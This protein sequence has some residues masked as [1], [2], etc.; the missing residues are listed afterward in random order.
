M[1]SDT[2][3]RYWWTTLLQGMLWI[4]FGTLMFLQPGISLLALTLMFGAFALADGLVSI[5][6]GIGGRHSNDSWWIWLLA[7]LVAVG[8]GLVT[9]FTPQITAFALLIC[10]A[11]WAIVTGVLEIIASIQ[12]R[13]EIQG[14]LWLG[15]AG[16]VS[17][18]FGVFLLAR[19]G[20][21]ALS[22][23]WVIALFAIVFGLVQVVRAFEARNFVRALRP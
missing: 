3:S 21:G 17:V 19:P 13:K 6:S 4:L 15:L 18:A 9:L 7:G 11:I 8:V 20:L 12:L 14:E 5:V 1:I 16:V 23:L 2:L 10:I 22:L